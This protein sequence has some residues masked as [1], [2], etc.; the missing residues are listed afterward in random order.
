VLG[1]LRELLAAAGYDEAGIRRAVLDG[2]RLSAAEG[3]AALP[4]RDDAD[5]PLLL[6]ARLFL[7]GEAIAAP[8]AIAALAPFS[9]GDLTE[10]VSV[11][12]GVVRAR[13]K[14]EPF[15]GLLIASDPAY[16][17]ASTVLGIGGVTRMLAALTVRRRCAAALDLCTG[18]GA[19]ALLAGR[20]ADHVVGVDL[21]EDALRLA[22]LNAALNVFEGIEW[23]LG[24]LF[25]P[26]GNERFD[27][28]TANPPFVVSPSRE[29]VFRDG[30]YEGDELSAAVVA[31]AAARLR[32]G[33][34]AHVACNWIAPLDGS[35]SNRPRDWVRDSGCDAVVLRYRRDSPVSYALRWNLTPGRTLE[36]ATAVAKPWLDYYRE[37]GIESL[38]TGVIVLR[39]RGGR[40]WVHED[41]LLRAPAGAA[42][43][44]V[45]RLFAGQ[46]ALAA[47]AN[48]HELLD[49]TLVPAPGVMVVERRRPSG[50]P[51]RARLSVEEGLPISGRISTACVQVIAALDGRRSLRD[52]I[53]LAARACGTSDEAL[54]NECLPTLTDS[55]GRGLLVP[56]AHGLAASRASAPAPG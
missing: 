43:D 17:G 29:F 10:V 38:V 24:D 3:I 45:E 9:P 28:V 1:R 35:W 25:E 5:E 48:V 13:V 27:L 31:G 44:H 37:R 12:D 7:G 23:R 53:D 54:T 33:G 18:S 46:D 20:H 42:G 6:L 49:L 41:E 11:E 21:S 30:G 47:L 8:Q 16:R 40:N 55:L 19:L 32:D 36:D 4:L 22:H 2:G 52:A 50:E 15:E 26:V 51:E 39:R 56:V 14:I 34:F